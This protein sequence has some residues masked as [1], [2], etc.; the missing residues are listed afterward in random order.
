MTNILLNR[1]LERRLFRLGAGLTAVG[2]VVAY[3]G[4]GAIA[5]VSFLAGGILA[6]GNLLWLR[7]SVSAIVLHDPKR[8]K[9]QV[10]GG[11]ILRL[12]LIPLCL[13]AMIRFLFLDVRAAVAGLAVFVCSVFVEGVLEAFGSN[14]K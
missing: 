6:G 11:F 1:D 12:L 14:P 3:L 9:F 10:L 4:F 8:S 7:S 13:Y 2:T 5:G